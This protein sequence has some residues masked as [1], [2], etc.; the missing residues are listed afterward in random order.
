[1]S[2]LFSAAHHNNV[3]I[4]I[5]ISI[6]SWLATYLYTLP[7]HASQW[8][9]LTGRVTPAGTVKASGEQRCVM[10]ESRGTTVQSP[11]ML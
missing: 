2:F 7:V 3:D 4:D 11:G 6:Y 10:L 1:M 8:V 9:M 5:F